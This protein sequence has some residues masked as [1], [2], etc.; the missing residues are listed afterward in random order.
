MLRR[1]RIF[2]ATGIQSVASSV[3]SDILRRTATLA[4]Q[5]LRTPP[6]SSPRCGSDAAPTEPAFD[7]ADQISPIRELI[8]KKELGARRRSATSSDYPLSLLTSH[9]SRSYQSLSSSI[10]MT[11]G[12]GEASLPLPNITSSGCRN[13]A[14][15]GSGNTMRSALRFLASSNSSAK[16]RGNV[17][18]IETSGYSPLICHDKQRRSASAVASDAS[19][20]NCQPDSLPPCTKVICG[21]QRSATSSAIVSAESGSAAGSTI[22]NK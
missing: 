18:L 3:R 11:I 5:P 14:E 6:A 2:I 22:N 13:L 12:H 10:T 9:F 16:E 21:P 20:L 4:F 17:W 7:R 15:S 1:R 19:P 8:P